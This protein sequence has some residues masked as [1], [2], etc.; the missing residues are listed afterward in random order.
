MKADSQETKSGTAET[1]ADRRRY[2]GLSGIE[3]AARGLS[4]LCLQSVSTL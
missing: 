1:A 2:G 3:T 4:Y